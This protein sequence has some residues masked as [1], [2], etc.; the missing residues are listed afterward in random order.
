MEKIM[1]RDFKKEKINIVSILHESISLYIKNFMLLIILSSIGSLISFLTIGINYLK[2]TYRGTS[3]FLWIAAVIVIASIPFLI[4]YIRM[5]ITTVL[6]ISCLYKDIGTGIKKAFVQSKEVFWR[7]IL[8][9]I[10]MSFITSIPAIGMALCWIYI[11]DESYK[12]ILELVFT[13]LFIFLQAVYGFGPIGSIV[14]KDR[15]NYFR[16]S[17]GLVKG[18]LFKVMTL[19]FI[20]NTV[21]YIPANVYKFILNDWTQISQ[22]NM[23]F[24]SIVQ[25]CCLLIIQPLFNTIIVIAYYKLKTRKEEVEQTLHHS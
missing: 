21:L 7:Y 11:R 9:A 24:I 2:N 5:Y 17:K 3:I 1:Q 20:T 16:V 25:Q 10:Q 12:I 8:I 18:D 4:L 6:Y 22:K 13:I 23:L 19:A 14:E 15:K